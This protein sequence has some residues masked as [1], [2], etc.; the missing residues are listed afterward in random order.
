[1]LYE[2]LMCYIEGGV[3]AANGRRYAGCADKTRPVTSV[4]YDIDHDV[5]FG[6]ESTSWDG[7]GVAFLD[8]EAPGYAIGRA[9]LVTKEQLEDIHAQEGKGAHWYPDVVELG[10]VGGI[11]AVTLTNRTRRVENA[12]S[13]GYLEVMRRGLE[14]A[15]WNGCDIDSQA[16]MERLRSR[17]MAR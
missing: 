3:C 14:E 4:A 13:E 7:R 11:P 6:N 9:Y 12:P 5:Y 1:M 10:Q 16:Y 17:A 2:R 8:V 15:L